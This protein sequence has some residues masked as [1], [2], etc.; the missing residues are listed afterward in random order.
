MQGRVAVPGVRRTETTASVWQ[1]QELQRHRAKRND[2][3]S[4]RDNDATHKADHSNTMGFSKQASDLSSTDSRTIES[5]LRT[6]SSRLLNGR[7]AFMLVLCDE[8]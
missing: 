3:A 8:T 2:D 7:E 4:R 5:N 6:Q 1:S